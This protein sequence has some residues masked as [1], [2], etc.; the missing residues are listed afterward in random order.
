ME[1]YVGFRYS[2]DN[3]STWLPTSGFS[4]FLVNKG[5]TALRREEQ[6]AEEELDND[7]SSVCVIAKARIIVILELDV[8]QFTPANTNAQNNYVFINK[9]RCSPLINMRYLPTTADEF[10]TT[11]NDL[12][13]AGTSG[14]WNTAY[15]VPED[16]PDIV[17]SGK[18]AIKEI[19]FTLKA[20]DA[21]TI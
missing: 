18:G 20:K 19:K 16:V 8:A 4:D 6:Q 15:L 14:D 10:F 12:T 9:L 5:H 7:E 17:P 11:F 1:G 3:G 2:T 21:Y 13:T